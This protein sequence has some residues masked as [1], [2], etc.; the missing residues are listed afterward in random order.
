MEFDFLSPV[1]DDV[2]EFVQGLSTQ[3]LGAKVVFHSHH[4]FPDL[5]QVKLALITV[6]EYRGADHIEPM[7]VNL[8]RKSLYQ[9]Y[10]GNWQHSLADL[11]H[12]EPGN[13]LQDT[14]FALRKVVERLLRQQVVPVVIGGSQDL[15]YPMYRAYEALEQMVNV[16]NVDAQFDIGRQD[17]PI[18]AQSFVSSMIVDEPNLLFHY[19]NVGY[20]TYFNAQEEIDL[21]DKLFFE[22]YRLGDMSANIT[23]AEPVM[24]DADLV[25]VDLHAV[26]S[27][28]SGI[29]LP[30][31]PNGFSGKE[32]CALTRY[33]GISD[34]VSAFG[35]FNMSHE[36]EQS[37]LLAQM[38]WY[39]IEGYHYRANDYPFGSKEQYTRFQVPVDDQLVMVFYKSNKTDRWWIE[40]NLNEG[41]TTKYKRNTLLPCSYEEYLQ[42]CQGDIPERWLKSQRKLLL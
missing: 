2:I 25:S 34:K 32:I 7:D 29:A 12:I 5:T 42:A 36:P 40:A 16:V 27:N 11:G 30:D 20:Q 38:I 19:C 22:A 21:M 24:R 35:I 26:Q 37:M 28:V 33:A 10:P 3:H 41:D 17:Q 13:T 1:S 14:Y 6:P 39:F 31:R 4:A 23:L 8:F 18:G 15:T 9:L